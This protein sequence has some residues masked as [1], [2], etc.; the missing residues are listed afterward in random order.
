MFR[1]LASASSQIVHS[2]AP[3]GQSARAMSH[4]LKSHSGAKK[5]FIPTGSGHYKRWQTGLR[6]LNST[7]SAERVNRLSRMVIASNSQKKMLRKALPYS[8]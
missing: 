3:F 5:R 4:K 7:F 2:L 6:H 1:S 8:C